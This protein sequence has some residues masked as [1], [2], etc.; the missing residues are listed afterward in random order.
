MKTKEMEISPENPDD[1]DF[2]ELWQYEPIP[3]DFTFVIR[4]PDDFREQVKRRLR[5][6]MLDR[7]YKIKEVSE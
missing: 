4:G 2:W 7:Q 6:G 1:V 5:F 3:P